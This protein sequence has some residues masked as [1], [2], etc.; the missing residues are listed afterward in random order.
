MTYGGTTVDDPTTDYNVA[1]DRVASNDYQLIKLVD[2]TEGSTAAIAGDATNGLDVDV[3]RVI[4]G[5]GA[6]HLGKAEDAGHTTGDSGVFVLGVRRDAPATGTSTDVDYA[7]INLDATGLVWARQPPRVRTTLCDLVTQAS[8]IAVN[9]QLVDE[10]RFDSA[11]LVA[12]GS[13]LIV[14]LVLESYNTTQIAAELNLYQVNPVPA[15]T[16][17]VWNQTDANEAASRPGPVVDFTVWKTQTDNIKSVGT[18][19][20]IPVSMGN[21]IALNCLDST[22]TSSFYLSIKTLSAVTPGA[23]TDYDLLVTY[24]AGV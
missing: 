10:F 3:T 8:A 24:I 9:D 16:N 19:A 21:P 20:G 22:D 1:R 11:S 7:S 12:N 5:T 13:L 17:S 6:T 2:G 4:P 23:T 15:G 14:G 18:V